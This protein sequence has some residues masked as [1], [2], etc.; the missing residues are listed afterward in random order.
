MISIFIKRMKSLG[1]FK[2]RK[3][4]KEKATLKMSWVCFGQSKN[5][6]YREQVRKKT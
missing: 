1:H 2:T 5:D 6:S 3:W 4:F